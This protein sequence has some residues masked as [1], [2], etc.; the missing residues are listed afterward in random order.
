MQEWD[1]R[2]RSIEPGTRG[3]MMKVID[4][5]RVVKAGD[6]SHGVG[7]TFALSQAAAPVGAASKN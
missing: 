2:S 5:K 4:R 7:P 6:F 1:T 3:E